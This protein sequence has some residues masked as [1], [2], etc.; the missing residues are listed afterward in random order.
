MDV[1]HRQKD[2]NASVGVS[3]PD[4]RTG[5]NKHSACDRRTL[6]ELSPFHGN[7]LSVHSANCANTFAPM[8]KRFRWTYTDV[9]CPAT[10]GSASEILNSLPVY[11]PERCE[12]FVQD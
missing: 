4:M 12:V 5:K 10:I 11:T 9:K 3:C 6:E 7:P 8:T 1:P 2:L